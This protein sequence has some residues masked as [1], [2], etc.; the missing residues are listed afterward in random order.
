MSQPEASDDLFTDTYRRLAGE[1]LAVSEPVAQKS[2]RPSVRERLV[3]CLWFDQNLTTDALRTES[4]EK[5]RVLSPG[6]WNLEKGPDFLKA[7]VRLG[8]GETV[9]GDVEVHVYASDWARH[10]H[11]KDAAY[12]SVILHAALWNDTDEPCVTNSHGADVPTIA[13]AAF[14]AGQLD[15]LAESVDPAE[16]PELAETGGGPCC[17]KLAALT[18][19]D[20]WL[21]RFLDHAGDE[22]ILRKVSRFE[23][24]LAGRS[25]DDV[26]YEGLAEVLGAKQN[27]TQLLQLARLAPYAELAAAASA[28]PEGSIVRAHAA[29]FSLSGLLPAE[30]DAGVDEESARYVSTLRAAWQA[31]R[32]QRAA[33]AMSRDQWCF[34]STRPVNFPP[35]RI[36]AL[37]AAVALSAPRGLLH[38]FLDML[39]GEGVDR[40]ARLRR[41]WGAWLEGLPGG[42]WAARCTFGSRPFRKPMRLIGRDR[43]GAIIVNVVVPALLLHA[44]RQHDADLERTLH[45]V[46]VSHPKLPK[47]NVTRFMRRRL[48]GERGDTANV[49]GSA[50]RQQGLYQLFRDCCEKGDLACRRCILIAAADR[51]AE[52]GQ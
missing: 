26:L 10:G 40:A 18:Q 4:G 38:T 8:R 21:A 1:L 52:R 13:L 37:G 35:R 44:R 30:G 42:Y 32:Q 43:A 23:N 46:F 51:Y 29:L 41:L 31:L 50:R 17:Q 36:A 49:V 34:S 28:A 6:W 5:L 20:Q 15:E 22:R 11:H 48:F 33:T 39:G 47:S 3:R 24:R 16:Y 25:L 9:R 27:K 19:P 2:P 12:D 7:A 45:K 14:V